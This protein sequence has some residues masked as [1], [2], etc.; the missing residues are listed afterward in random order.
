MAKLHGHIETN[1]IM[2]RRAETGAGANVHVEH[3][4]G[5]A[6]PVLLGVKG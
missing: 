3:I 2:K 6:T 1:E 5:G 4:E